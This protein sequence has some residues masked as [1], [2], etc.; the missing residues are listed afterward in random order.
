MRIRTSLVIVY[1]SIL[2][3]SP[4]Y[5]NEWESEC[6]RLDAQVTETFKKNWVYKH[7]SERIVEKYLN[8]LNDKKLPLKKRRAAQGYIV[9]ALKLCVKKYSD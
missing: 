6:I 4:S 2:S 8:W 9:E 3:L 1:L 5:S 7:F